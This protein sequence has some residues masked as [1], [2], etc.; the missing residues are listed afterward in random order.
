MV[1]EERLVALVVGVRDQRDHRRDQLGA[2]GLDVDRLAVRP[3]ERHPVVV[4]G[5]VAG[6]EL[7]L[8]DGGLER[9]VPQGRRLLQVGLA[10]REVAQERASG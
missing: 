9:D 10:A 8:G 7:G 5:V 2:G 4:A 1:P 6:L 3:V